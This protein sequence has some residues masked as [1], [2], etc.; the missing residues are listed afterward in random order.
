MTRDE[1]REAILAGE[2]NAYLRESA[3]AAILLAS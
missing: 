3:G 1:L 2:C